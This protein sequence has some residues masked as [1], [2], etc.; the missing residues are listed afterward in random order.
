MYRKNT[1][2]IFLLTAL[3]LLVPAVS[4]AENRGPSTMIETRPFDTDD[5]ITATVMQSFATDK[6]LKGSDI[7]VKTNHANVDLTGTVNSKAASDRAVAIVNRIPEVDK[8]HNKLKVDH[9]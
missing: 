2:A 1:G 4:H 6:V 9:R 8:V 3:S 7:K 5:H